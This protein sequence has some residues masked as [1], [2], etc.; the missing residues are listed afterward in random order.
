M[1]ATTAPGTTAPGTA[2]AAAPSYP[3]PRYLRMGAG[4][5]AVIA[6]AIAFVIA[7][8]ATSRANAHALSPTALAGL[9][10][11]AALTNG[12]IAWINAMAAGALDR[13]NGT[14]VVDCGDT[15]RH[16]LAADPFERTRLWRGAFASGLTMAAWAAA[17][18]GLLAVA[19]NGRH[20]N[21]AVTFVALA[22]F[23]ALVAGAVD[24]AGRHRGVHAVAAA[25]RTEPVPLRRRAWRDIALPLALFQV[26]VNAALTVL[27]FHDYV[28]GKDTG[29]HILTRTV[30]MADVPV[31]VVVVAIVFNL[32]VGSWGKAEAA[33][34]RVEP[35]EG[36]ADKPAPVG[37]QAFVY[38]ALLGLILGR[39]F[40]FVLPDAPS[41]AWVAAVRAAFAGVMIFVASGLAFVRGALNDKAV[42]K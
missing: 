8:L 34:G 26:L 28:P 18:G 3:L 21:L 29:F 9:V 35:E 39:L 37:V 10:A 22:V 38:M 40:A 27:L 23:Q 17:G 1:A 12:V 6:V 30:A 32:V 41:L 24:V 7:A 20:A 16:T 5:G 31:S 14:A 15:C 36:R 2:T 13:V 4:L 42:A 33:L 25:T 11:G 19:L